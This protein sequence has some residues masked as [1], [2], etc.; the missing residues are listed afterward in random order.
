MARA[1]GMA[2]GSVAVSRAGTPTDLSVFP[3]VTDGTLLEQTNIGAA[4]G[5]RVRL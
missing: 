4:I 5:V 3:V 1:V 2:V